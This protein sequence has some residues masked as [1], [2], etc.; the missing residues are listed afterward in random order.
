ME[1]RNNAWNNVFCKS[2][3]D[4]EGVNENDDMNNWHLEVNFS[5]RASELIS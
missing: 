5:D 3:S 4:G 1:Q 2:P